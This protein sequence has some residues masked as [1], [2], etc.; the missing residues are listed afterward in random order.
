M[1]LVKCPE[2]GH[3]VSTLATSCPHCGCPLGNHAPS[4][5]QPS[6]Q[7]EKKPNGHA[8]ATIVVVSIVI[9]ALGA[10]AAWHIFFRGSDNADE[11]AA[12]DNIV[13]YQ[14]EGRL[15]S[16]AEALSTYLDTYNPDAHHYSQLKA[17]GDRFFVERTD[18]QAAEG[19][20]TLASVRHFLDV[21]PDGLYLKQAQTK[22]D[23]LSFVEANQADTREAYEHYLAQFPQGRYTADARQKMNELDSAELSP[24]EETAINGTLDAHFNALADNNRAAIETTLAPVISS[25]IGK[26][27]PELED[28]YAYMQHMHSSSRI[29]FFSVKNPTITKVK[30]QGRSIYNVQFTLDEET[31]SSSSVRHAHLDTEDGVA[32]NGDGEADA[33]KPDNVKRFSGTAVL[34]ESM[35]ITSLVLRQ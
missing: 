16:L 5:P 34:D 23:S 1:S 2:C 25:Y 7:P 33:P 10:A 19:S 32:S 4:Q 13:R 28:I 29:L 15:D 11:R 35:K 9:L 6:A 31:Y 21:H 26:A 20:L 14:N 30:L 12:Y 8:V 27:N 17:L 3:E 22:L 18:W 24:E